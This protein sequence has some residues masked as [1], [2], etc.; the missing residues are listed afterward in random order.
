MHQQM[1]VKAVTPHI[2]ISVL[3]AQMTIVSIVRVTNF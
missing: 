3:E 2:V 1:L